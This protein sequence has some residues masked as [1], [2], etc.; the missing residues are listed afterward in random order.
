MKYSF[1]SD[2]PKN[3]VTFLLYHFLNQLI[4]IKKIRDLRDFRRFLKEKY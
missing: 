4:I 3:D 1:P 2:K